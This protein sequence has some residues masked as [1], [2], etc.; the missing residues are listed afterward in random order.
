MHDKPII[1]RDHGI[2]YRKTF[3]GSSLLD[4]PIADIDDFD[5]PN[6]YEF[7]HAATPYNIPVVRNQRDMQLHEW[8]AVLQRLKDRETVGVVVNTN[9]DEPMPDDPNLIDLRGKTNM[10]QAVEIL[11]H[12]TGYLGIDSCFAILASQLFA[13]DDLLI[14]TINPHV[15]ERCHEYYQPHDVINF[16]TPVFGKPR[17]LAKERPSYPEGRIVELRCNALIGIRNYTWGER[18]E[19]D[20]ERAENMLL[21]KQAIEVI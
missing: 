9:P 17:Y 20:H 4:E 3:Y 14:R 19:V 1:M 12:A 18:V 15:V 8:H 10:P 2:L 21:C 13:P 11:K 5:L 16:L 7:I 6:S